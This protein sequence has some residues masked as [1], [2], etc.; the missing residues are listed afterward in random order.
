VS[1]ATT[2]EERAARNEA[3]FRDANEEIA[4]AAAEMGAMP[5]VPFLCECEDPRCTAIMRVTLHVYGGVRRHPR[6]FLVRKGHDSDER[7]VDE[8]DGFVVIE[9]DGRAGE[10]AEELA[11]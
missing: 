1:E 8:G 9:K 11:P 3:T 2:S 7:I 10:V 4:E 5:R 6:R